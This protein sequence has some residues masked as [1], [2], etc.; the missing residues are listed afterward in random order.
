MLHISTTLHICTRLHAAHMCNFICATCPQVL[1]GLQLPGA[2]AHTPGEI[3]LKARIAQVDSPSA[4]GAG[5]RPMQAEL[6][7]PYPVA[8]RSS[9]A[10]AHS[11]L[12]RLSLAPKTSDTNAQAKV[13]AT[14]WGC[15]IW[16]A[17]KRD[18]AR[19]ERAQLAMI[20][21]ARCISLGVRVL[22][23]ACVCLR[24]DCTCVYLRKAAGAG[25][26]MQCAFARAD[27]D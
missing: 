18:R 24:L 23:C 6:S 26:F 19:Y 16:F 3:D 13:S 5:G 17:C 22:A 21:L 12:A 15:C 10:R 9:G 4:V 20:F 8:G 2:R 25:R 14:G 11:E 27:E 7:S 1:N